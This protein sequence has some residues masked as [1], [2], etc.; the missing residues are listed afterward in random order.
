MSF[1]SA[2]AAPLVMVCGPAG[3]GKTTDIMRAVGHAAVVACTA[4]ALK[5]VLPLLGDDAKAMAEQDCD[6]IEGMIALIDQ[7]KA[8]NASAAGKKKP[9]KWFVADEFSHAAERTFQVLERKVSGHKLWGEMRR[10]A[11]AFRDAARSAQIGVVVN[12]W[13]Q[14]PQT[15]ANGKF[16]RGG[17][18]LPSD[19]PEHFPGIADCIVMAEHNAD[20]YPFPWVYRTQGDANWALKNRD[21]TTPNIA[22]LNIGEILRAGGYSVPYPV[23]LQPYDPWVS[24]RATIFAGI[25]VPQWRQACEISFQELLAERLDTRRAKW[26]VYDAYARAYLRVAAAQRQSTYAAG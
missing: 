1:D 7:I 2:A 9:V 23:G 13:E 24:A 8:F 3:S 14:G 11:L 22:P 12:A 4:G 16:I 26:L 15:K 18:R 21:A 25:P 20:A 17:P 6:S 10:I 19:L 5:P